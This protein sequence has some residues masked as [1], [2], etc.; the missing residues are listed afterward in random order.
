ML[1]GDF[2][3][4]STGWGP[5][6]SD[7]LTFGD[8]LSSDNGNNRGAYR[9]SELDRLVRVARTS[10]DPR[11]R[12]DAFGKIQ[13]IIVTDAVIV[14]GY[15]RARLYVIDPAVTGVVR[16]VTGPDPDWTR[17]RITPSVSR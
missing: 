13:Q 3:M 2:D 16:R 7:P 12:M 4:V 10:T 5:D 9:N 1:A 8:L 14:P 11:T 6:Y 17:A 15:E